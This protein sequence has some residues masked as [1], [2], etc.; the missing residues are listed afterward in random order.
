[1][2]TELITMVLSLLGDIPISGKPPVD[3]Q[4]PAVYATWVTNRT[5]EFACPDLSEGV[6]PAGATMIVTRTVPMPEGTSIT[7]M[8]PVTVYPKTK[9]CTAKLRE[10]HWSIFPSS[11]DGDLFLK[12]C[13]EHGCD[14]WASRVATDQ[15]VVNYALEKRDWKIDH[16]PGGNDYSYPDGVFEVWPRGERSFAK[17]LGTGKSALRAVA[18]ALKGERP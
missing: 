16:Y 5:V 18:D 7:A 10:P 8:M 4:P 11:A 13:A 12:N 17:P 6:G 14:E 3:V 9:S 15:E 1:M 2:N